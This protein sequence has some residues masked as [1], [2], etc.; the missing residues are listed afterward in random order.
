MLDTV[1]T[2]TGNGLQDIVERQEDWEW[3][4]NERRAKSCKYLVCCHSGGEKRRTAFLI[5]KI[6]GVR[7]SKIDPKSGE[8][9]SAVQ[10]SEWA[11]LDIADAWGGWQ[12]PVHYASLEEL[13]IN[14]L[15]LEFQKMPVSNGSGGSLSLTIA[16]AKAGL[17]RQYDVTPENVEILIKG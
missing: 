6:K 14:L 17:A 13:G 5:G 16:Q 12:N 3:V 15:D 4:L 1:V 8:K 2:F 10:F 9:R 11:N 7:F